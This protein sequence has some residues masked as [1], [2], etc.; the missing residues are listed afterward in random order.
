M[1][2]G[3]GS[4]AVLALSTGERSPH[5]SGDAAASV[6]GVRASVLP[7][8]R[9]GGARCGTWNMAVF[10]AAAWHTSI[11]GTSASLMSSVL[12]ECVRAERV[13]VSRVQRRP[14][15]SWC[16]WRCARLLL[17]R[18]FRSAK[19]LARKPRRSSAAMFWS[20]AGSSVTDASWW[21]RISVAGCHGTCQ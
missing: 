18:R 20:I 15:L 9:C 16:A 21:K 19:N 13:L 7:R 1:A 10:I 4:D 11:C 6:G 8:A 12:S 14:P 2:A 3:S 5:E 17:L